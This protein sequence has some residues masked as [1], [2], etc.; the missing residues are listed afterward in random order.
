M[1]GRARLDAELIN[2]CSSSS[3]LH[4]S[5]R[6]SC[7]TCSRRQSLLA[8]FDALLTFQPLSTSENGRQRPMAAFA[9]HHATI[10]HYVK[11]TV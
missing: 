8:N 7:C 4:C 5:S 11:L 10:M 2:R 3:S 6:M 9:D 1:G